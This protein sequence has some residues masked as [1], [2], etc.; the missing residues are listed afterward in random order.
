[1]LTLQRSALTIAGEVDHG[2]GQEEAHFSTAH[3][4]CMAF[5]AVENK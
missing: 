1:M 2:K 5:I 3:R 4:L